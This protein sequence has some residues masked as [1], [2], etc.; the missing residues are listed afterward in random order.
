M[1]ALPHVVP[2]SVDGQWLVIMYHRNNLPQNV[3]CIEV[4]SYSGE[5]TLVLLARLHHRAHAYP[6]TKPLWPLIL[7]R[8]KAAFVFAL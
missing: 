1:D 8:P 3:A 4:P 2:P 7:D 6:E 5:L